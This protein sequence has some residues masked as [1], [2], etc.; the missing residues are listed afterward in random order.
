[1]SY[2]WVDVVIVLLGSD[3]PADQVVSHRVN[4][5]L[6]VVS[7]SGHISVLHQCIVDVPAE[8]TFKVGDI[9]HNGYSSHT[10]LLPLVCVCLWFG[11]H[12]HQ[13]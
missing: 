11:S 8:G 1:M 3:P 7:R 12:L 13:N 9:L 6:R 10:D 5:R 2:L 4:H